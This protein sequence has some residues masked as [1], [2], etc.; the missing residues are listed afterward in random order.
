MIKYGIGNMIYLLVDILII[1]YC[2]M[3]FGVFICGISGKF[4]NGNGNGNG[5]L[6]DCCD[7]HFNITTVTHYWH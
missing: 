5:D 3:D 7:T 1:M 2:L 4:G 6:C